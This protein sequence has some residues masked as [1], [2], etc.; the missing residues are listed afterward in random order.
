MQPEKNSRQ[1]SP[2]ILVL[3]L[4]V[5][6]L[7]TLMQDNYLAIARISWV[8]LAFLFI[9]RESFILYACFFFAAFFHSAGFASHFIFTIKHFH[10]A[11]A[12]GCISQLLKQGVFWDWGLIKRILGYFIPFAILIILGLLNY[13]RISPTLTSIRIPLNLLLTMSC[14]AALSVLLLSRGGSEEER[15]RTV[16]Q[17]VHFLT[18]GISLQILLGM[19]NGAFGT[20]YLQ[21]VLFHNNHIGMF[22][23]MGFFFALFNFKTGV[24]KSFDR[25]VS[26]FLALI[27]F[28]GILLSCSRT[29]WISFFISYVCYL[30][31]SKRLIENWTWKNF[32]QIPKRRRILISA[33]V[34]LLI[35]LSLTNQMVYD[36]VMLLNQLV[37]PDYWQY[38][39]ADKQN[40]GCFGIY[41]LRD[42]QN[43]LES[44]R[45]NPLIGV[46]FTR[47]VV[48]IHGLH[49]LVL[50]ATG[51]LGLSVMLFYGIYLL[52]RLW[53]KIQPRP[54]NTPVE[55]YLALS[56]LTTAI[57]WFFISFMESF[58]L[59][60]TVW[61][62]FALM[63]YVF[64]Y[65]RELNQKSPQ[66]N[67]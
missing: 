57:A 39:L 6:L 60:F 41:R 38:I 59:Q 16:R 62:T 67:R 58:F 21:I 48:D 61:V 9:L 2:A 18:A 20:R 26:F 24:R 3:T 12:L 33:G 29:S 64:E 5:S 35:G 30:I 55:K 27:L 8:L 36:R 43:V 23:V 45:T 11:L 63:I 13:F 51:I 47:T 7:G 14:A 40:F 44:L 50:S 42:M 56:A 19:I 37:S 15:I 34:G 46:G 49:F 32:L 66:G 1:P 53:N 54:E 25:A 4:A 65:R 10:I 31:L 22:S 28:F 17:C 52:N